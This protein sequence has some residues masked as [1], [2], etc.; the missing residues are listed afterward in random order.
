MHVRVVS[1]PPS[2]MGSDALLLLIVKAVVFRKVGIVR[3]SGEMPE[4]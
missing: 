4:R 1:L 3:H 2:L